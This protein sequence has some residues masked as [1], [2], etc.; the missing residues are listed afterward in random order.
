MN[1]LNLNPPAIVR[2]VDSLSQLASQINGAHAA[3]QKAFRDGLTFARQIGAMLRIAKEKCGH[4]NWLPR[5]A[6]RLTFS[7][8]QDRK[9][10]R[11]DREGDRVKSELSS[12]LNAVL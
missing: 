9:Y 2:E 8:R 5:V 7:D 12:E 6:K 11:L 1:A 10:M 3:G 4:R